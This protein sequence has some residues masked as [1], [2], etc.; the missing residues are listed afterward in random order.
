[1]YNI[2]GILVALLALFKHIK[3]IGRSYDVAFFDGVT[4]IV[5]IGA[6]VMLCLQSLQ[7]TKIFDEEDSNEDSNKEV[8]KTKANIKSN[9]SKQ[10]YVASL[11]V[12]FVLCCY[13]VLARDSQT[14]VVVGAVIVGGLALFFYYNH[15]RLFLSSIPYLLAF[16]EIIVLMIL[17]NIDWKRELLRYGYYRDKDMFLFLLFSS[18]VIMYTVYRL[19]QKQKK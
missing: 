14:L 15:K 10:I 1:M 6:L 9:K 18:P 4:L 5:Y 7:A 16:Y 19:V 11:Y 8:K 17:S 13:P 3:I 2:F 12:L